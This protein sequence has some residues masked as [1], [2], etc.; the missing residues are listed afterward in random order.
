[1]YTYKHSYMNINYRKLTYKEIQEQK[2]I[3]E[4][5]H[6]IKTLKQKYDVDVPDFDI[7]IKKYKLLQTDKIYRGRSREY[8]FYACVYYALGKPISEKDYCSCFGLNFR[9]FWRFSSKIEILE[10]FEKTRT[11]N[12]II[13][14]HELFDLKIDD[15]TISIEI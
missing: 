7:V 3:N 8:M 1:M 4:I 6:M 11:E 13:D 9:F 5:K 10:Q 2:S 14:L 12:K 15:L